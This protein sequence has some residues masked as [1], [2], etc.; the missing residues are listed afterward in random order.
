ML[1]KGLDRHPV[2]L[3]S[4]CVLF[5]HWH[6]VL[7]PAGTGALIDFMT[8][9]SLGDR[10][11]PLRFVRTYNSHFGWVHNYGERLVRKVDGSITWIDS[12]GSSWSFTDSGAGYWS[13]PTRKPAGTT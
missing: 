1:Q 10:G 13:P 3:L 5:N 2:Q 6:L 4:Y 7:E 11:L 9:L 12:K 8:D